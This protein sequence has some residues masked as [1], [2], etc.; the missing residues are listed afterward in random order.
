[1]SKLSSPRT[2]RG[3]RTEPH[4]R[5]GMGLK[6]AVIGGGS[7][8]TP[9]LV[10]GFTRRADR[11]TVDEIALLDIDPERLAIVGGLAQRR[12]A[13][14]G[15]TG[16]VVQTTDRDAAIDGAD[17]VL[18]QLR[19]GGQHARLGDETLPPKFGLIGQETVGAGGFAK[20]LRTVP[21]VLEIAEA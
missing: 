16:R 3:P 17:F 15:W 10:D 7:T 1:M 9:E 2:K 11:L 5:G 8:Y 6:L 13:R 18:I 12:L 20:A 21:V 14:Q 4:G 19:V